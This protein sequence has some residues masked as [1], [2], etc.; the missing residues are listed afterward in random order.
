M[1]P[2]AVYR[3]GVYPP[4][5]QFTQFA[6]DVLADAFHEA[7]NR[8]IKKRRDMMPWHQQGMA[9]HGL[10]PMHD[11]E[12]QATVDM[13]SIATGPSDRGGLTAPD[14]AHSFMDDVVHGAR[15]GGAAG[16]KHA[17]GLGTVIGAPLGYLGAGVATLA[18][19]SL[20]SGVKGAVNRLTS[21]GPYDLDEHGGINLSPPAILAPSSSS[22]STAVTPDVMLVEGTN[23]HI[24]PSYLPDREGAP[25]PKPWGF[26][27]KNQH[28]VADKFESTGEHPFFPGKKYT[29]RKWVP[30]P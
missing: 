28:M 7:H 22:S 15:S 27:K 9:R 3:P 2:R 4:T 10:K 29:G 18:A 16:A 5:P 1:L 30:A 26:L 6:D 24:E 25:R 20:V 11:A 21:H 19:S 8:L 13:H 12:V 14:G 17:W 23:T